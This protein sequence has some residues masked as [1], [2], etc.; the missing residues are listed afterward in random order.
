MKFSAALLAFIA[1]AAAQLTYL[2]APEEQWIAPIAPQVVGNACS[3]S[4]TDMVVCTGSTGILSAFNAKA[5]DPSTQAWGYSPTA[6]GVMFSTSGVTFSESDAFGS[7]AV[8]GTTDVVEG[9]SV[10]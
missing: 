1:P 5:A 6:L 10:W 8:Y 7:F 2:A 3:Y 9:S 4:S